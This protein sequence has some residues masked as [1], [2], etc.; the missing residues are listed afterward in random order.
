MKIPKIQW[1]F[2]P[3]EYRTF[4]VDS[5]FMSLSS[6]TPDHKWTKHWPQSMDQSAVFDELFNLQTK[7]I[8]N[9]K[10]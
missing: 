7:K 3:V 9:L 5:F 1:D 10:E 8:L 6:Q 2:F 4:S